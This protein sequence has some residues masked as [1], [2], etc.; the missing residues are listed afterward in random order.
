MAGHSFVTRLITRV[1]F[2]TKFFMD[3]CDA[4]VSV[5]AKTMFPALMDM[6]VDLFAFNVE[7]YSQQKTLSIA[8]PKDKKSKSKTRRGRKGGDRHKLRWLTQALISDPGEILGKKHARDF[9]G[10]RRILTG[11]RSHFW[12]LGAFAQRLMFWLWFIVRLSQFFVDWWNG[13]VAAGYCEE[14]GTPILLCHEVIDGSAALVGWN[15][16]NFWTILKQRGNITWNVASG[17]S[18]EY[19]LT[20]LFTCYVTTNTPDLP[21]TVDFR[22]RSVSGDGSSKNLATTT[23][24]IVEGAAI[25]VSLDAVV[26]K[27]NF[28]AIEAR[29]SYGF[30]EFHDCYLHA[31]GPSKDRFKGL[32]RFP[33]DERSTRMSPLNPPH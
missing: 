19:D 15:S 11:G 31:F 29:C 32:V 6:L 3:P 2:I 18:R 14:R 22:L 12:L 25:T 33:Q 28:F 20:V 1:N 21:I 24:E 16:V 5:Y 17:R 10:A 26:P 23:I 9:G 30:V 8:Y 7:E 13:L 27:N 4:P